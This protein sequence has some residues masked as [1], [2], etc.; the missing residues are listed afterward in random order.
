M[1]VVHAHVVSL[2]EWL[3]ISRNLDDS[4]PSLSEPD[5]GGLDLGRCMCVPCWTKLEAVRNKN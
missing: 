3:N 2:N 1:A 5:T 4:L